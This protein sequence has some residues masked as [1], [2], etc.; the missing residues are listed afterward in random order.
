MA[1]TGVM[2]TKKGRFRMWMVVGV[3]VMLT[4]C[5]TVP[6]SFRPTDP[7]RPYE[8]SHRLLAHVFAAHVKDGI[9]DY[10]AVQ[11]DDRFPAY[12]AQLDRMDPNALA[13]RNE[14]MAFWINAYNAFAVNGI[15]D[16]F[17]P[18]SLVGR[19]RYFIGR[20]YRVGGSTI[21]LYDLERHALIKQ[22][23]EPLI[24]F[25]IVCASM[26]CPKL[27]SWSY[28]PEQLNMQLDRVARE[29]INDPTRN[30]FDRKKKVASLSMIFKWF[31]ED[32]TK[33]AGSIVSYITRYV[34]DPELVQDLMQSD[35]RIEYLEYD[36]SLN[37]IP[38]RET[39]YVGRS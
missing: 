31:E 32:F 15:L 7:L 13:T 35:Y 20:G 17:S 27:Q 26:S 22:F 5:S 25:A 4:A 28:D 11:T 39:T 10:P 33:A 18:T 36:W 29:F 6:T 24:H 16:R 34:N 2:V 19:Y 3:A 12:L 8:F 23:Q 30:R 9:V 21:N 14:R 38:P 37:G 1:D